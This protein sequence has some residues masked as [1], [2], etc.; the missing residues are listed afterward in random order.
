MPI[1]FIS[2]F[3]VFLTSTAAYAA[4]PAKTFEAVLKELQ[5]S[6]TQVSA[7]VVNLTNTRDILSV[8]ADH[9]LN[10]ASSI[11]LFTA[12]V[13]LKRLGIDYQ[14]KTEVYQNPDQSVCV[15]GGG[16]PSFVM[17][18]LYL[19]VEGLKR[20]GLESYSGKILLDTTVFDSDYYPDG[21]SDQDSERAYNAP[22]SGL[23]FD[24]NTVTV[25]VNPTQKGKLA[26]V[27]TDYPFDFLK[28]HSKVVTTSGA[29]DVSWGKKGSVV[30]LGGKIN[31]NADE[32]HK[33]FRIADPERGWGQALASMFETLGVKAKGKV[34]ISNGTCLGK[35]LY[36]DTSPPLSFIVQLMDK[37]SNNFIA[38]TLVK[39]LDHEVNHHPGTAVGGLK[40]I[41]DE[42]EKIDIHAD[43]NGRKFVAG[44][45]LTR[46]NAM[47]ASDFIRLL[48]TINHEKLFLPEIFASLPIAGLD[49]TLKKKYLRSEVAERLRAKTG[50]LNGVQS[51]V[52]IYPNH[53]GEWIGIA[54]ITNGRQGIP[55]VALAKY[56]NTL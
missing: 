54:I 15:K 46:G 47:A 42:L 10:P 43:K 1:K 16:D 4:K 8:N 13:A 23:N 26:R 28:V 19:L 27:G 56:L 14:F 7:Q 22:I 45:G 24:Y 17:E 18:D 3:A 38:D 33:P 49:G 9:A 39:T 25:L 12:Y 36:T 53:D 37:Y 31:V 2:L 20:R 32:W 29:T 55:E 21:R 41:R 5:K 40:F 6:G 52:G 30:S 35:P 50:T 11:K 48:K 51:L 34:K 44:S